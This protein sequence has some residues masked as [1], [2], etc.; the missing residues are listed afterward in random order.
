[1]APTVSTAD[2]PSF[3]QGGNAFLLSCARTLLRASCVA[4]HGS[5][6]CAELTAEISHWIA[7]HGYPDEYATKLLGAGQLNPPRVNN[8]RR[9]RIEKCRLMGTHA[10]ASFQLDDKALFADSVGRPF[11]NA[12]RP[13][14]SACEIEPQRGLRTR[15]YRAFRTPGTAL[16]SKFFLLN[17]HA[18]QLDTTTP[19]VAY[20][21]AGVGTGG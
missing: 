8:I 3:N 19:T 5:C 15:R 18:S 7:D 16:P 20:T 17:Q 10:T 1:M 4:R 9:G 6:P 13:C 21:K 2:G 12:V 14:A 11:S